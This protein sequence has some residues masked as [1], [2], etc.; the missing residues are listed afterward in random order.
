MISFKLGVVTH[1]YDKVGIAVL[2]L[3]NDLAVGE[4]INFLKEG[5]ELFSQTVTL[6]QKEHEKV[7]AAKRGEVV[8]I[9]TQKEAPVGTEVYKISS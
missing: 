4:K 3:E 7:A 9:G 6:I 2:I 1:F 5:E 8:G